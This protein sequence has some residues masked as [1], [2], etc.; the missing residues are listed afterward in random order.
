MSATLLVAWSPGEVRGVLVEAGRAVD[1]R[2]EREHQES[3]IDVRFA[4][5]VT[6]IVPALGAA[7]IDI[8]LDSPA[9][10]PLRRR[11]RSDLVEGAAILV[12][13]TK[14]ARGTK[15]PEVRRLTQSG[16]RLDGES[17]PRRL[18]PPK[19]PIIRLLSSLLD[20]PLAAII[21]NDADTMLAARGYLRTARSDLQDVVEL[22]SGEDLF[23]AH[24][25]ADAF[26]NALA[27]QISLASGAV[28]TFES[29]A[30]ATMIDIDMAQASESGG[31]MDQA[32]LATNLGAAEAIGS[33]LRLRGISG[34][35][36][37]DFI[38][39]T[40]KE[41]RQQVWDRLAIS[42][43]GDRSPVELHGWT[44]LGHFELTRR[45][46]R[47]SLA[48]IM[49]CPF[50]PVATAMTATLEALARIAF[51]SAR[52][53]PITVHAGPAVSGLLDGILAEAFALAAR[54]S[55]RRVVL[56]RCSH[57]DGNHLTIDGV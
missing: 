53:G 45:R 34:A 9:F 20:A 42:V 40:N 19:P 31:S 6:R 51:A 54:R 12:V 7:F 11:G 37:V 8:G 3:L 28:V 25:L 27:R 15:P 55:G 48:E 14:D 41:H 13:V 47:A 4:G 24:G 38:S 26:E 43:A 10:F 2:V 35:I 56:E 57:S 32:I 21:V 49:L 33:Q 22:R 44:R 52:G 17:I 23:A 18:D 39:M 46:G 16:V 29:T 5:R 30:A 36:I 50:E 1:L